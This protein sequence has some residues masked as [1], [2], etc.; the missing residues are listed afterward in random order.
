MGRVVRFIFMKTSATD[1]DYQTPIHLK[2]RLG[3]LMSAVPTK[4]GTLDVIRSHPGHT[5]WRLVMLVDQVHVCRCNF[6][7]IKS[8]RRVI[9]V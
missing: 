6:I 9:L 2:T 4:L 1:Q 5:S 3:H 8:V 7:M